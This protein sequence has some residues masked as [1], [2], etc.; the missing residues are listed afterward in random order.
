MELFENYD[1]R[2]DKINDIL[3]KYNIDILHTNGQSPDFYGRLAN[4]FYRKAKV[5]VTIHNTDG[6]SKKTEVLLKELTDV[7]TAVSNDA[8]LYC[9]EKL[10]IKNAV[11]INN[12][13][14]F[15]RYRTESG[16]NENII[17]SVGRVLPQ[18]GFINIVRV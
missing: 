11:I 6:Y 13:I 7:Y 18:K 5:V 3:K 2:I 17:L 15:E 1:R 14:D 8:E 4:L 12:G 10:G 16:A 9:R